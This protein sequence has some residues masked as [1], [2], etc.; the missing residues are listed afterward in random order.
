MLHPLARPAPVGMLD[1]PSTASP[2]LNMSRSSCRRAPL[3]PV[4]QCV[5]GSCGDPSLE[6]DDRLTIRPLL[7]LTIAPR[8]LAPRD[9]IADGGRHPGGADRKTAAKVA[10]GDRSAPAL[11]MEGIHRSPPE[12]RALLV[13]CLAER[14]EGAPGERQI[15]VAHGH[16][17]H[18][19]AR[20]QKS[21]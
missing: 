20:C 21:R 11:L 7:R 19:L 8:T 3:G 2:P 12:A 16:R 5:P 4:H 13:R 18:P 10:G 17:A 9:G 14:G 6:P 1:H 15:D